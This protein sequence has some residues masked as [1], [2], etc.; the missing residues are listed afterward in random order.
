[1]LIQASH[2][3]G[4]KS[5]LHWDRAMGHGEEEDGCGGRSGCVKREV[6]RKGVLCRCPRPLEVLP[7][8]VLRAGG[9]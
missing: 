3:W 1:M 7:V 2:A 8:S 6:G 5:P 9:I 4:E